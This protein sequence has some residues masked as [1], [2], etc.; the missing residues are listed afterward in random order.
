MRLAHHLSCV[1]HS[2]TNYQIYRN[3]QGTIEVTNS[4]FKE[5]CESGST[6]SKKLKTVKFHLLGSIF[7]LDYRF[8]RID[9]QMWYVLDFGCKYT[10]HI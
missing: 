8:R 10:D 1:C 4:G 9:H 2:T 3:H 5:H 6:R 7:K